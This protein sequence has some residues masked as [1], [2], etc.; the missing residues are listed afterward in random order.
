MQF[1]R[2]YM[3]WLIALLFF[4]ISPDKINGSGIHNILFENSSCVYLI[5]ARD[6]WSWNLLA[7]NIQF[8]SVNVQQFKK[9]V[10]RKLPFVCNGYIIISDDHKTINTLFSSIQINLFF[11]PHLTVLL[12]LNSFKYLKFSE[13]KKATELQNLEIVVATKEDNGTHAVSLRHGDINKMEYFSKKY[14]HQWIPN[15]ILRK[16]NR[17]FSVVYFNCPPFAKLD[18]KS[19]F[20][21]GIEL[22]IIKETLKDLPIE[23]VFL[24]QIDGLIRHSHSESIKLI[25]HNKYDAAVCAHWINKLLTEFNVTRTNAYI[26]NCINFLVP[27]PQL[28]PD[29]SFI[30]QSFQATI[31][32]LYFATV[33]TSIYAPQ[34]GLKL[35]CHV[36]QVDSSYSIAIIRLLSLGGVT[37]FP[38]LKFSTVRVLL[39]TLSM[40]S[41]LLSIYYCAGLATS[42]RFPR[43]SNKLNNIDD[44]LDNNLKWTDSSATNF[45]QI[46]MNQTRIPKL[47]KLA[48]NFEC[49]QSSSKGNEL[50]RQKKYGLIVQT[51]AGKSI[52][53]VM[54]SEILEKDNRNILKMIHE[55]I[56]CFYI[57]LP[58]RYN[59][60][61]LEIFNQAYSKYTEY[62]FIKYWLQR[63]VN[64]RKYSYMNLFFRT[65]SDEVRQY[66]TL[67]KL[68]GVFYFLLAGHGLA[69]V[70][71]LFEKW[72]LL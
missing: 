33:L 66:I 13:I 45:F 34:I 4:T 20:S 10:L 52:K 32:S 16:Y 51:C 23:F 42:L 64:T 58:L 36:Q 31:W 11:K 71:F 65:Y 44:M 72:L 59:S 9:F 37:R 35:I 47:V 60:P 21:S 49:F 17:T 67:E 68:H 53:Y 25:S 55:D 48:K 50:I 56:A 5:T 1:R 27:R 7:L 19:N 6:S 3:L 46:W 54:Y 63:Y 39:V 43:F 12:L 41:L 29:Y 61:Y 40:Y 70:V 22:Q 8:V 28:L 57:T 62:G 24:E 38:Y 2:N 18:N 69:G 26:L 15:K 30:F 14:Q